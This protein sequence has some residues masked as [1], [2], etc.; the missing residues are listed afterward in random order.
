MYEW[1]QL[2]HQRG[3][4][5]VRNQGIPRALRSSDNIDGLCHVCKVLPWSDMYAQMQQEQD[6]VG[7]TMPKHDLFF[8][9]PDFEPPVYKL[10]TLRYHLESAFHG[11]QLCALMLV[12]AFSRSASPRGTPRW[13]EDHQVSR[14]GSVGFDMNRFLGEQSPALEELDLDEECYMCFGMNPD[15]YFSLNEWM[16]SVHIPDSTGNAQL[17]VSFGPAAE[18]PASVKLRLSGSTVEFA[19]RW[20]EV[21]DSQHKCCLNLSE[22]PPTLPTRVVKICDDS[23]KLNPRI[24]ISNGERRDTSLRVIAGLHQHRCNLTPQT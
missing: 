16:L 17:Q 20:L 10:S 22:Q 15:V 21:C 13:L 23:G 14:D 8:S 5:E 4:I 1:L 6:R 18:S 2:E 3:S 12:A 24:H 9:D 11:C 7:S 19:K